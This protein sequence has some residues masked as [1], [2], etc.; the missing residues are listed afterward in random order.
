ME[1]INRCDYDYIMNKYHDQEKPFDPHNRFVRHDTIFDAST[2]M[3]PEALA[4]G[5]L[6]QDDRLQALSHPVRKAR[7]FQ[8]I[9]ENTR[10][11]CDRRDIVPAIN[12][13]D[14]QLNKTVAAR[15]RKEVFG[16]LIPDIEEKRAYLERNGIVTIWPDY[17]H[18]VP[19][20]DRILSL[21]FPGLLAESE[22]N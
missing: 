8:Y 4:A 13:V 16:A 3:D 19:Y 18:S 12:M 11:A 20:R 14:R 7:A 15:W 22:Q 17:D 1:Y 5:I 10:I 9:L 2:G 6:E 21:G